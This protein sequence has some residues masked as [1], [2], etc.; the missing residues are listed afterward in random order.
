MKTYDDIFSELLT[1]IAPNNIINKEYYNQNEQYDEEKGK[2]FFLEKYKKGNITQKM[3][4][5]PKEEKI[6]CNK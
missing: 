5:I 4:L 6:H 1:K 2:K 3:F